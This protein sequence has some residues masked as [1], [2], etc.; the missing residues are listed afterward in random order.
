M[1]GTLATLIAGKVRYISV[2]AVCVI[3]YPHH[4][5]RLRFHQSGVAVRRHHVAGRR[6]N[7]AD[8]SVPDAHDYR[9]RSDPPRGG[10]KALARRF[11]AGAAGPLLASFLVSDANVRGVLVMGS[12]ALVLGFAMILVIHMTAK[13]E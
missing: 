8:Q 3:V 12:V 2:F 13:R 4:L 6:H 9:S 7:A 10:C 1:G 5:E 11:S